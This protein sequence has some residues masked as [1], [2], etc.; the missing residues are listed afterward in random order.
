MRIF[1]RIHQKLNWSPRAY[2]GLI[3]GFLALGYLASATYHSLKP[4][5][6]GLN[7]TGKLRHAPIK[8]IADQTY[9]DAQGVQQQQ[10]QIFNEIVVYVAKGW[11][12]LIIGALQVIMMWLINRLQPD[13]A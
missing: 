4:L 9:I 8:F 3:L 10:H 5:P 6:E 13:K 11:M 12:N 7:Y 2:V 1:Q